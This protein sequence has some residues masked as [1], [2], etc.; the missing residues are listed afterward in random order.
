MTSIPAAMACSGSASSPN[1]IAKRATIPHGIT[2]I[3]VAGTAIMFA[4]ME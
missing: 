3:P 4:A 1:G 2:H